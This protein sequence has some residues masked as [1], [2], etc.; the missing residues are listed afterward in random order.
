MKD[1]PVGFVEVSVTGD[2]LQ[3]PQELTPAQEA[4]VT[5]LDAIRAESK[6]VRE[7]SHTF[8]QMVQQRQGETLPA[9]RANAAQRAVT[10]RRSVVAGLRQD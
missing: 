5:R 3:P 10:E 7:R 9:W 2:T 4:F 8:A 1:R 6:S